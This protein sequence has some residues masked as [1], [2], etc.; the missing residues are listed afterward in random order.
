MVRSLLFNAHFRRWTLALA[1]AALVLAL[2]GITVW[3]R[4][5]DRGRIDTFARTGLRAAVE[6]VDPRRVH[7]PPSAERTEEAFAFLLEEART[8]S[9]GHGID[10]G[11][12]QCPFHPCGG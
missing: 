4:R 2:T 6:A 5:G 10:E 8:D 7:P 3:L 11:T 9:I 12:V 1:G